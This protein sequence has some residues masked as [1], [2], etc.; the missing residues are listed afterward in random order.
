MFITW[1]TG[2]ALLT[3]VDVL[4]TSDVHTIL[5]AETSDFMSPCTLSSVM[6]KPSWQLCT[7]FVP[8]QGL[9]RWFTNGDERQHNF[10][11]VLYR[12]CLLLSNLSAPAAFVFQ[13]FD[14]QGQGAGPKKTDYPIKHEFIAW[15]YTRH[16]DDSGVRSEQ[17]RN[18]DGAPSLK[19]T[20]VRQV[21]V[22]SSS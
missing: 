8:C 17:G 21:R 2:S 14:A 20:H 7:S 5:P 12:S 9:G 6:K 19:S 22:V 1:H 4:P 10:R 11:L 18:G 16:N 3:L 13:V 15:E